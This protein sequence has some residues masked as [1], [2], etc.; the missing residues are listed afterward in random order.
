MHVELWKTAVAAA[1][2]MYALAVYRRTSPPVAATRRALLIAMRTTAFALLGLLLV[3]PSCVSSRVDSRRALVVAL[4]DHSRSMGLADA[5]GTGRLAAAALGLDRF[6]RELRERTDADLDIVPFADVLAPGPLRADSSLTA[7]GEGTDVGGALEAAQRRYRAANLAAIVLLTDGRVTRGMMTAGGDIGVPVYAVGLGDTTEKPDV[8]VEEVM[9]ER[10][11]YRGTKVSVEAVIRAS[12]FRGKTLDLRL[13][14][15]G[16]VRDDATIAL[17]KDAGVFSAVFEFVPAE[18]GRRRLS[19]EALPVPGKQYGILHDRGAQGPAARPLHR[20]VSRLE[21]DLRQ[22]PR[23]TFETAG[24]GG[25]LV[26][27]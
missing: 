1:L 21:H 11:A 17:K 19:V 14:E 8:S 20:S 9:Y 2:V 23:E 13:M 12:G 16:R 22:E 25:N 10:T 4:I 24:G 5:G 3:N 26:G 18:E 6:R 15:E 27:A 7:D